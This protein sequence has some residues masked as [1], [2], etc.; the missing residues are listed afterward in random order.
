MSSNTGKLE[1]LNSIE[2]F[3]PITVNVDH[4]KKSHLATFPYPYMNGKLHLGH[5]FTLSKVDFISTFKRQQG[6]NALF[7]FGFH[8]TG[9]PISASAYKLKEELAGRPVDVSVINLLKGIGFSD[10]KPFTDPI[11]WIK[12]F[13]KYAIESLTRF[14]AGIDWRRSFITTDIN[15]YYDSFVKYQFNKLRKLGY[16]NFGKRYTIYCPIDN[17]PCLDHD[18]RKGEGVK[19]E[20]VILRKVLVDNNL[21][22]LVRS[23]NIK[24]IEK[25]VLYKNKKLIKFLLNEKQYLIEEDLYENLKLQVENI[26]FIA[27]MTASEII[28]SLIKLEF[29]DKEINAK[30]VNKPLQNGEKE[31]ECQEYN[32]IFSMDNEKLELVQTENFVKIFI[33]E[34]TVISRSGAK[35]VVSL[36]D[37]WYIDY[38]L[39]EWKE[40]ARKCVQ[41]MILTDDTR[42]KIS[43]HLE[44]LYKWGF[45]RSFGLGTKIPWDPQYLIDSLSD[46][47]IYNAFYT[48]KHLLFTDL[49]GNE[50]IFPKDQLCDD[51]WKY[52]F[53]D[54]SELPENLISYKEI[55]D[56]C[57]ESFEYFYPVDVRVTG[58]D[59]IGNHILFFIFN[60]VALFDEKYWPKSIFSNGHL[61]LNSAKMSKSDNN[62]L[63]VEDCISKFG[64]SAT[65]MC[66]AE[67]GD[68]NEDA[69]FIESVANAFVLKLYTFTK[70]VENLNETNE[71]E[72]I[73]K[74]A[75]EEKDKRSSFVNEWFLQALSKNVSEAIKSHENMVYR[76]VMKYGFHENINLLELYKLLGGCNNSL[77]NLGYKAIISLMYP[78]IPSLGNYLLKIKF[79][80][81]ISLPTVLK[82]EEDKIKAIE[83]IK[84]VSS[85]I[86]ALKKDNTA[87]EIHVSREYPE[88]KKECMD[89]ANKCDQKS[90]IL[91]QIDNI[92]KKYEINKKKVVLFCMDYFEY[93]QRYVVEFDEFDVLSMFSDYLKNS[94]NLSVKVVL[95]DQGEPLNPSFK[96]SKVL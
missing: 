30:I 65:R 18:R 69:N 31:I 50:E 21:T 89:L 91:S 79:N 23:K 80:G 37:Q 36:L 63:T 96:F 87:V 51:V 9:M 64:A 75:V 58:K 25:I 35:C 54:I 52:I 14:H 7:P 32:Q 49:E 56:N 93:K 1:Y 13:P 12:T 85:R 88:W 28:T 8:C 61:M 57:K 81:D 59:L 92:V 38:S 62:F 33:P 77:I 94:C 83:H 60:H 40:K 78:I 39:P 16:L 6:Y 42:S 67:C 44:G 4:N 27:N 46:S 66:L 68:T 71:M 45:S 95:S 48:V 43:E 86:T 55:L 3:E 70:S 84:S 22:I 74:M 26:K 53:G 73:D 90:Q 24:E 5:L 76:D 19:P 2:I 11:H 41:K 15:K 82:T 17:Q 72:M 10:P 20:P 47:T 29:I 34:D